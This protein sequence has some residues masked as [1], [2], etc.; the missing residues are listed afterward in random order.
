MNDRLFALRLRRGVLLARIDV[1]RGQ[2]TEYASDWKGQLTIADQGMAII[3]FFRAHPLLVAGISA[4][5]I[6]RRKRVAGLISGALLIRKGYRF[7]AAFLQ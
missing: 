7:I 6:V 5:V 4:L 1:Q 2:L 3:R